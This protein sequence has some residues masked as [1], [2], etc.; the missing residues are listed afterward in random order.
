M[1]PRPHAASITHGLP[2]HAASALPFCR[3]QQKNELKNPLHGTAG[4]LQVSSGMQLMGTVPSLPDP[5][6]W[7]LWCKAG[8]ATFLVVTGTGYT[9]C[10]SPP[11][12]D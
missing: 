6:R 8:G 3:V 4:Q 2:W 1:S 7:R 9:P 10:C 12:F 5:K 11:R